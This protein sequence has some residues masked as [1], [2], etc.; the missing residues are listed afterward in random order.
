MGD[1]M[2]RSKSPHQL[3]P[4]EDLWAVIAQDEM[5]ETVTAHFLPGEDGNLVSDFHTWL[6]G[7]FSE[8][9]NR[10]TVLTSLVVDV[11]HG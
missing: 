9:L 4:L 1:R 3:R 2:I 6:A 11:L 7:N 8:D 5:L 10:G